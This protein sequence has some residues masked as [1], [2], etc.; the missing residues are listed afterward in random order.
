M[1]MSEEEIDA[2]IIARLGESDSLNEFR[3]YVKPLYKIAQQ[4]FLSATQRLWNAYWSDKLSNHLQG[5]LL[6]L[7]YIAMI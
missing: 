5:I 4:A 6:N 7:L 3:F 2:E 1:D